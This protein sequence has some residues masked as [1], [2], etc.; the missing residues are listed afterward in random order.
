MNEAMSRGVR[1]FAAMMLAAIAFCACAHSPQDSIDDAYRRG[2]ISA[3]D[4][5]RLTEESRAKQQA[6]QEAAMRESNQ[7]PRTDYAS[8]KL[9]FP[10]PAEDPLHSGRPIEETR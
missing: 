3:A 2:Q 10:Q 6:G 8:K 7:Q 5:Q 4:K 1:T 9:V